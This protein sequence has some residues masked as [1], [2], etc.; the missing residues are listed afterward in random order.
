MLLQK[1]FIKKMLSMLYAYVKPAKFNFGQ[2][3]IDWYPCWENTF[4]QKGLFGR[5]S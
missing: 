2:V 5:F 4:A 1:Y 3:L